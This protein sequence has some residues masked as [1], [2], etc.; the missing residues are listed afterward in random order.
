MTA[1]RVLLI[2]DCEFRISSGLFVAFWFSAIHLVLHFTKIPQLRIANFG[3]RISNFFGSV[4]RVLVF[5]HSLGSPLHKNSAIEDCESRIANFEFLRVCL[6]PFGFQPFTWFSAS[7]K[8]RN[9]KSAFHNSLLSLVQREPPLAVERVKS[10][11]LDEVVSFSG[12]P[13]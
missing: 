9:S 13:A 2:S 8:F 4:C 5:S 6:S 1:T 10:L 12:N 7:Q 11:S 3:L